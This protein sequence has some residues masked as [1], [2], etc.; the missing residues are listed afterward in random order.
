MPRGR[1]AKANVAGL[2]YDQVAHQEKTT[3]YDP[4]LSTFQGDALAQAGPAIARA[5]L[6]DIL[7]ARFGVRC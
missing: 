1:P 6:E 3:V 4:E 5:V 7:V 2:L